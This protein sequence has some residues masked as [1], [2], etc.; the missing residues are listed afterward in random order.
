MF[1]RL[2]RSMAHKDVTLIIVSQ[3]R[4]KMGITFGRATTRSGGR[5]LDFYASQV[6]FLAHTGR[7]TKT[8]SGLKRPT[9]I[10][11]RAKIDKNKVAL[12]FREADFSIRFGYGI[13]DAQ[14][15]VDWLAQ[16]NMLKSADIQKD[17]VKNYLNYVLSLDP[18]EGD[19]ELL[20]LRDIVQEKWYLIEAKMLTSRSKYGA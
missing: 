14:A 12:P 7:I 6:A 16:T 19:A 20:R 1:R 5:A 3:I 8:V 10:K 9:G 13:D 11:V 2:V 18:E 15:C 17:E 4:D